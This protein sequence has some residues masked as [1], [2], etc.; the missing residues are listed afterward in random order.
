MN[1]EK[2]VSELKNEPYLKNLMCIKVKHKKAKQITALFMYRFFNAE[3]EL[4]GRT[5]S[6]SS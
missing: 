2:C 5:K 1:P 6:N 4:I 3:H